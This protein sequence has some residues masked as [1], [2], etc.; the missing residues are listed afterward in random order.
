MLVPRNTQTLPVAPTILLARYLTLCTKGLPF[1]PHTTWQSQGASAAHTACNRAQRYCKEK[2]TGG[3]DPAGKALE[4]FRKARLH[5]VK[6]ERHME[7]KNDLWRSDAL[8][9]V[10]QSWV[11]VPQ[12]QLALVS[13]LVGTAFPGSLTGLTR[14]CHQRKHPASTRWLLPPPSETSRN[15]T[16]TEPFPLLR[17][18]CCSV[19]LVCISEAR[20]TVCRPL[21]MRVGAHLRKPAE[22]QQFQR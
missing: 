14:A 8:T 15:E 4:G 9:P 12:A 1:H 21:R 13:P 16:S 11:L 3:P 5:T 6:H 20:E 2:K 18:R 10:N 17:Y 22:L 7:N 19:P